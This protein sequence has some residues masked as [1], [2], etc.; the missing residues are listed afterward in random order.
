MYLPDLASQFWALERVANRSSCVRRR[1]GAV[2]FS[3]EGVL[4]S[5]GFNHPEDLAQNCAENCPRAKSDV[6]A[7]SSYKDGPGKCIAIHA[8]DA[9][10]RKTTPEE[11][12]GGTMMITANPCQ[13]CWKL[14]EASGLAGWI[15]VK[16]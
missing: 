11:R 1:I 7:Y 9:A 15:V 2:I 14:L 3:S 5:T 8:E 10:L 4:L 12:K 6:P 13:D 16:K